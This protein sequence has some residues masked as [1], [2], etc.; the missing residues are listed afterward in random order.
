[1][2][3]YEILPISD[4]TCDLSKTQHR[5]SDWTITPM[6]MKGMHLF[7][8]GSYECQTLLN[9]PTKSSSL[10]S[11]N[12]VGE[13]MDGFLCRVHGI[14]NPTKMNVISKNNNMLP[15]PLDEMSS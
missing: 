1:M 3:R 15:N 9:V 7:N 10:Q 8:N 14:P 13:I 12:Q 6:S 2:P 11:S 4:T 5:S